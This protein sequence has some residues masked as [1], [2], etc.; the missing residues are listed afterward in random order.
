MQHKNTVSVF[1]AYCFFKS[2]YV[3][4]ISSEVCFIILNLGVFAD[5][6]FIEYYY[7]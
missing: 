6:T 7:I 1:I 5:T 4:F 2:I 3:V